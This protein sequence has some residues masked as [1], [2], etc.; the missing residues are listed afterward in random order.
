MAPEIIEMS[1][2]PSAACDIWSLGCTILELTTGK[3]PHF[4]LTPMAAL[5]RIVQD[6]APRL[7]AGVSE[8]LRD[9]LLQC[10]NHEAVLRADAKSL[11]NHAWLQRA[12]GRS[13]KSLESWD[14][15]RKLQHFL[16]ASRRPE[17]ITDVRLKPAVPS[18][19][20]MEINNGSNR[21]VDIKRQKVLTS[22]TASIGHKVPT[23]PAI[24]FS[25]PSHS[26]DILGKYRE[27]NDD[28]EHGFGV[29]GVKGGPSV[30]RECSVGSSPVREDVTLSASLVK[31]HSGC[32]SWN[33]GTYQCDDAD[34]TRESTAGG[35]DSSLSLRIIEADDNVVDPFVGFFVDD[36]D[37]LHS[38]IRNREMQTREEVDS[39]L[40]QLAMCG[41]AG[42]SGRSLALRL[43]KLL[44]PYDEEHVLSEFGAV[45]LVESLQ[46]SAC[47]MSALQVTRVLLLRSANA[48][49]MLVSLGIAPVLVSL[50]QITANNNPPIELFGS[51]LNLFARRCSESFLRA[52]IFNGGI[53]LAVELLV[54]PDQTACSPS[55][56]TA[57]LA[58]AEFLLNA[59]EAKSTRV[60]P[61]SPSRAALCR[62]LALRDAPSK[63]AASLKASFDVDDS[64][65]RSAAITVVRALAALCD[66]DA[67]VKEA[68]SASRTAHTMLGVLASFTTRV[69]CGWQ[70]DI[71]GDAEARLAVRLLRS[72]KAVTMAS[73]AALDSLAACGAIET[74]VAILA[75][76]Q[77]GI[78]EKMGS[79]LR[80]VPRRDELE[81]QL[82]PTV[83]YL[84]RINPLRLARAA[85]CGAAMLLAACAARR[86][87]LKQFAIAI[88]C[89]L[90]HAAANDYQGN[91]GTEL[92]RVGGVR[93]Y[94][95]LLVEV[96]WGVRALAALSAW[97]RTDARVE[98][99]MAQPDCVYS[100]AHLF[101]R[102]DRDEL[103]QSLPLLLDICEASLLVTRALLDVCIGSRR[104]AFAFELGRK[105][106][107]YASAFVRKTLLEILRAILN[108]SNSPRIV[109]LATNLDT[110]LVL[111]LTDKL[112][113]DQILVMDLARK[114]L[115]Q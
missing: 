105:L 73:A 28:I 17:D 85:R 4:D 11:L 16:Q 78:T 100:I 48:A 94:V 102:L 44:E 22:Q 47:A 32:L 43:N 34:T 9:F 12:S 30:S 84:C 31:L 29:L 72:L 103:Q 112:T 26:I 83:Y 21:T 41:S 33:W 13:H 5:F 15:G 108:A 113:S 90:C 76:T 56:L 95:H 64:P 8:A 58:G 88:L 63:L 40:F 74:V 53:Q 51:I 75:A 59:L 65:D 7:P 20:K 54:P 89:E 81:D 97:L 80:E 77:A 68:V 19:I 50:V 18:I 14:T 106:E 86:R 61:L 36:R 79:V 6:D 109:L 114:L 55:Q 39:H 98:A 27:T 46:S 23:A 2:P 91:I 111:L 104:L 107:G 110:T 99:A 3:P 37:F 66:A 42:E 38:A 82:V 25:L 69:T 1:A 52:F 35:R 60:Q 93:L 10:F 92:W 70:Q 101:K 45:S 115:L 67:V 62:I 71:D 49:E 24:E 57:A 96:Y 87:H